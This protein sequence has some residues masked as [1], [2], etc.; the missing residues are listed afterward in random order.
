MAWND[1]PLNAGAVGKTVSGLGLTQTAAMTLEVAAGSVVT[2]ADGVTHTF[3]PLQNH[4]FSADATNPTQVFMGI[5]SNG[6]GTVDLWVDVYVDDGFTKRADIPAGFS[7]VAEVAWFTIA[8]NETD[9]INGTL[10]RRTWV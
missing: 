8:A 6:I 7:L 3:T 4:T 5:I 2:H 9:L 1:L 10:N